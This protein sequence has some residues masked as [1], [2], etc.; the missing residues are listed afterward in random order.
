MSRTPLLVGAA[1]LAL[2]LLSADLVGVAHDLTPKFSEGQELTI[3][4]EF[5]AAFGLDDAT[6]KMGEMELIPEVPTVDMEMEGV[7]EMTESILSVSDGA[8]TKMRRT[9][10]EESYAVSGEAGMQ[11]QYQD[12]DE[13]DEGPLSGRTIELTK[14]DDGWDVEDVTEDAGS[15]DEAG[16]MALTFA[17]ERSHWEQ[18]LPSR[19]VEV[20]GTWDVGESM[21]EEM[22]RMMSAV[23]AEDS[24]M[25]PMMGMMEGLQDSMEFEAKGKLVSVEG[26][27]ARIEW[28]VEAELIIDDLFGMVREVMDPDMAGEIPEDADGGMEFAVEMSGS[29]VFDMEAHQLT[30]ASMEGEFAI[31]GEFAMSQQGTTIEASADASGTVELNSTIEVQ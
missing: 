23:A 29:G 15:L 18:L 9:H 26:G 1:A 19:P 31:S 10:V 4:T 14:T 24:D 12:F 8:I 20:G 25:A 28:T 27:M 11:G 3:R 30:E 22:T 6:A 13:S 5:V 7:T 16:E 2:P 17:T 21:F